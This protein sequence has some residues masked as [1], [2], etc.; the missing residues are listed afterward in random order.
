[1]N[2]PQLDDYTRVSTAIGLAVWALI[3]FLLYRLVR[4]FLSRSNVTAGATANATAE[5]GDS[6][7]GARADVG[8]IHLHIHIGNGPSISSGGADDDSRTISISPELL[9]SGT[10]DG[11]GIRSLP[12]GARYGANEGGSPDLSLPVATNRRRKVRSNVVEMSN[13]ENDE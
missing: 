1:M 8:G 9:R 10:D 7:S 2:G 5:S 13:G 4:K 6:N 11:S 12:S 3:A